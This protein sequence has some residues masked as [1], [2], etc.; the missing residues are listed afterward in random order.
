MYSINDLE[1]EIR[2]LQIK[3]NLARVQ[4]TCFWSTERP[5]EAKQ[6]SF[7]RTMCPITCRRW[8]VSMD[9]FIDNI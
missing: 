9:Q 5:S 7:P 2:S 1:I 4:P 6:S 8:W 3:R